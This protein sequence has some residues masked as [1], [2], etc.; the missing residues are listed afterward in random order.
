MSNPLLEVKTVLDDVLAIIDACEQEP[1][2]VFRGA[3]LMLLTLREH[4]D[5]LPDELRHRFSKLMT[6][7]EENA[8]IQHPDIGFAEIK[9]FHIA[10]LRAI[11]LPRAQIVH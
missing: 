10:V 11:Q 4:T 9:R 3:T 6:R 1:A 5:Q 8:W 2:R 7:L